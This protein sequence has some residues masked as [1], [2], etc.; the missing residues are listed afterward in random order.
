M[1]NNLDEQIRQDEIFVLKVAV[2]V[3]IVLAVVFYGAWSPY[4]ER[5]FPSLV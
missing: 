1:P 5:L 3:V 4:V 2:F